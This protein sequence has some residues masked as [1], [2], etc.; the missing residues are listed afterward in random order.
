MHAISVSDGTLKSWL[1]L[2]LPHIGLRVSS[3]ASNLTNLNY[4]V[5]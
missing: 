1:D 4:V 5:C 2:P 3:R